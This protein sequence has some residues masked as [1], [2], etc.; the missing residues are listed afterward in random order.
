MLRYFNIPT[1][2]LIQES[3][4]SKSYVYVLQSATDSGHVK[5]GKA[6][7]VCARMSQIGLAVFNLET[8]KAIVCKNE[9]Q[10][11]ALERYLHTVF[12]DNH[13]PKDT[14]EDGA[15]E[16]FT[17]SQQDVLDVAIQMGH[18]VKGDI[19]FAPKSVKQ[20]APKNVKLSSEVIYN[21]LLLYSLNYVVKGN[22]LW[23]KN[24]DIADELWSLVF[25]YDNGAIPLFTKMVSG[26]DWIGLQ[27]N[28]HLME[29][30]LVPSN[31]KT[32][33]SKT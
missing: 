31:I 24:K 20:L 4:M 32:M 22:V 14:G 10:A 18:E 33:L 25:R 30:E 15:S 8:V 12:E 9:K 13:S 7:D 17:V 5:I 27:V 11:N 3:F 16:W 26:S 28:A 19:V 2:Y 6:N 29:D 21:T 23:M 1:Y